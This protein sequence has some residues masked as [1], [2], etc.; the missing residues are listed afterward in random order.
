MRIY[1]TSWMLVDCLHDCSKLFL[2]DYFLPS[3]TFVTFV[4]IVP[5]PVLNIPLAELAV[6]WQCCFGYIMFV[7]WY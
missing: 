6:T 5:A 1:A 2:F 7:S 3:F 4:P